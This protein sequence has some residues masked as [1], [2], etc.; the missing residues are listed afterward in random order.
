MS[1]VEV[2]N[3]RKSRFGSFVALLGVLFAFGAMSA[4][5]Q[6]FLINKKFVNVVGVPNTQVNVLGPGQT[7]YLEFNM[8]NSSTGTLVA[9]MTDTLPAGISGDPS[10]TPVVTDWTGAVGANGCVPGAATLTATASTI[11]IANFS[12]PNTPAAG[13]RPDCRIVFRVIG[14][15]SALPVGQSN[16]TNTVPGSA[17]S[18][19]GNGGPY[20]SDD[21]SASL[22]VLPIINAALSK[23]FSPTTVAIGGNSVMTFTI[24]NNATYSLNNATLTDAVPAG[25]EP[26]T[27]PAPTSSCG[28]SVAVSGQN[29]TLTGGTIAASGSCTVTV[30]VKGLVGAPS[31]APHTN[32]IPA[33]ALTTAEGVTNSALASAPLIVLDTLTIE[34]FHD[35]SSTV[36]KTPGQVISTRV[37]FTNYSTALTNATLTD[38]LPAGLVLAANPNPVSYCGGTA[39]AVA[40]AS[41]FTMTGM[42]IPA[43]NL[44]TGVPGTCDVYFSTVVTAAATGTLENKINPSDVTNTQLKPPVAATSAFVTVVPTPGGAG[45]PNGGNWGSMSVQKGFAS[46]GNSNGG[47]AL[48]DQGQPFW[49][50]LSAYNPSYDWRFTNGTITDILPLGV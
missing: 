21:F 28:G 20:A 4:Q 12:Y 40:G 50:Y 8:F 23:A 15:P 32:T 3:V 16:V 19:T 34:K 39:A 13:I 35:G 9:N 49:L 37:R 6:N 17:T 22:Q 11:S 5:A 44:T 25:V 1:Q 18:A 7:S 36:T 10:F 33:N 48:V 27:T 43:A 31:T 24:S 30:T 45:A 29:V 14:N 47:Y 42:T 26:Q 46:N 41:T 38:N 2:K